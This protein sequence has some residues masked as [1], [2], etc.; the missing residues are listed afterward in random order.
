M[1]VYEEGGGSYHWFGV[2]WYLRIPFFIFIFLACDV[3]LLS[4]CDLFLTRL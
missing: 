3:V 1:C 4:W 2:F